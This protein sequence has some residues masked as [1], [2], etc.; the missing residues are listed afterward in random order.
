M[1][2][3]ELEALHRL[4]EECV[5]YQRAGNY[6]KA[7]DCMERALV[8][9]RH[10]FGVSSPEVTHACKA[11]AEMCNLLS[12]SYLQQDNYAVTIDLL[13]KAEILSQHHPAEK[14]TTLNNLAC[15]YR[16]LGKLHAAMTCLKR[17]LEIEKKL[18]N[19]KNAADTHLN[20]CAVLSQL[21]KHKQALEH[22]QDALLILQDE[23]FKVN[24]SHST[25]TFSTN[26][27]KT[28][29]GPSVDENLVRASLDRVSVMC[30]AYHNI[31]V[32]QEFLKDYQNSVLSYKKVP[33]R[34]TKPLLAIVGLT[35]FSCV[36]GVGLAEQYL[37]VDHQITTTVRNSYLA[38]K[39]TIATK[40]RALSPSPGKDM[41]APNK[42]PSRLLHS[43]RGGSANAPWGGSLVR[44]P[45]PLS[46]NHGDLPS[47]R[48][49]IADAL[50]KPGVLP[51]IASPVKTMSPR[52]PFFSPRYRFDQDPVVVATASPEKE[53]ATRKAE[54]SATSIDN[55]ASSQSV[56]GPNIEAEAKPPSVSPELDRTMEF[57]SDGIQAEKMDHE[58]EDFK[59]AAEEGEAIPEDATFLAEDTEVETSGFDAVDDPM[60]SALMKD[61]DDVAMEMVPDSDLVD[62]EEIGVISGDHD[63]SE[64]AVFAQYQHEFREAV[65]DGEVSESYQILNDNPGEAVNEIDQILKSAGIFNSSDENENEPVQQY[66]PVKEE[67][68]RDI[69]MQRD[70]FTEDTY[71]SSDLPTYQEDPESH[72]VDQVIEG[73]GEPQVADQVA[74]NSG[75][76]LDVD[77]VE[78]N[79]A[80]G[81]TRS[82]TE[83]S[84][85]AELS[86]EVVRLDEPIV[87]T[88]SGIF[89]EHHDGNMSTGLFDDVPQSSENATQLHASDSLNPANP[90]SAE[91]WI[92]ESHYHRQELETWQVE[93]SPAPAIPDHFDNASSDLNGPMPEFV[94]EPQEFI[95]SSPLVATHDT[96]P[97]EVVDDAHTYAELPADSAENLEHF[98]AAVSDD[99]I[100]HDTNELHAV[101]EDLTDHAN[102]AA[103]VHDHAAS[104]DYSQGVPDGTYLS[105]VPIE[106]M[107]GHYEWTEENMTDGSTHPE[108][109]EHDGT[110][111]GEYPDWNTNHGE[112]AVE[113]QN[114]TDVPEG[115]VSESLA[116]TAPSDSETV[117]WL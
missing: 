99:A 50:A 12:M 23:F 6:L 102:L 34:S 57:Q 5:H 38:A 117:T 15:Y 20:I 85:R 9:R 89:D 18:Q 61:A 47:P 96:P 65:I 42:G 63:E 112:Y 44:N 93:T 91:E 62:R 30:I 107:E 10:F 64:A 29:P 92:V 55:S 8:L 80:E 11:L 46:K 88:A 40:A 52:D 36:Q 54:E 90:T 3:L 77:H 19:V 14:A 81:S 56:V 75:V 60:N 21:G 72:V 74:V 1:S 41:K 43:P 95:Q 110:Y 83:L 113:G 104:W 45:S 33:S 7:F 67:A 106:H 94:D 71:T 58:D 66:T 51:P 108:W 39:R 13:K 16:R 111:Q 73:S 76:S 101:T 37:G 25:A 82:P 59:Y 35:E 78:V 24:D 84:E 70:A 109:Q 114:T 2:R 116:V 31:G 48:S 97:N 103:I 86:Q 105:D 49:I 53:D 100:T 17:A 22:S 26:E 98:A 115:S 87:L 32:E 69:I 27:V 28:A 4:D 79:N 68:F